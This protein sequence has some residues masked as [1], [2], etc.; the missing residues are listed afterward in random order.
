MS[1]AGLDLHTLAAAITRPHQLSH[2]EPP[3]SRWLTMAQWCH[4][5]RSRLN[6]REAAFIADMCRRLKWFDPTVR[7]RAWL[8]TIADRLRQ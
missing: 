4:E 1:S 2:W 6:E 8:E 3:P 7:Q 5:R